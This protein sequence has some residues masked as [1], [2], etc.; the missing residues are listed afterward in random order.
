MT[1]ALDS[2][3]VPLAL[4]Q[5]DIER[6]MAIRVG[7]GEQEEQ[8]CTINGA[9]NAKEPTMSSTEATYVVRHNGRVL[10]GLGRTDCVT[11]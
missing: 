6:L 8:Y 4:L 7:T 3:V 1:S 9:V 10:A 2:S 5:N 11:L